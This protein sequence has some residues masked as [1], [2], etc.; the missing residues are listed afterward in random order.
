MCP[1]CPHRTVH[2]VLQFLLRKYKNNFIVGDI[3]CYELGIEYPFELGDIKYNM[4]SSV[5]I[6]QGVA[7]SGFEGIIIAFIGDSTFFHSGIPG[8]INARWNN[9]P[10]LV[11]VFDN[12]VTAL[13]GGQPNP[14][15]GIKAT[16][17][18]APQILIEDIARAI[19]IKFVKVLDPYNIKETREVLSEAIKYITHN[20][21]PA[22]VVSRRDCALIYTRL[23]RRKGIS[24]PKYQVD[25]ERCTGCRVCTNYY[26]CPAIKW[27]EKKNIVE[28]IDELCIG[29]GVCAQIC[30]YKA[31]MRES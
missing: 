5:G 8:L 13:T 6:A 14:G 28:I 19:G 27:D 11:I 23:A 15:S 4:G 29:C 21:E 18:E 17:E 22:V 7:L 20:K 24:L 26:A 30:P 9:S 2:Y 1:G 3:G 25:K 31:I 16:G 12:R 10:I